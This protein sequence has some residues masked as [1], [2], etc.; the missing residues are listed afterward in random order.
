M[1]L[2]HSVRSLNGPA[3]IGHDAVAEPVVSATTRPATNDVVSPSHYGC[4]SSG[5]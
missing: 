3:G 5:P 4:S 1:P 2:N